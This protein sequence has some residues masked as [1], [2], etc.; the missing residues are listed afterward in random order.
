MLRNFL[1]PPT[2]YSQAYMQHTPT[3]EET[4]IITLNIHFI[5]NR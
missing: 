1:S 5:L 3:T 4:L 2:V